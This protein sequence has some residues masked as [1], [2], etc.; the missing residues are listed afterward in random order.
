MRRE[1]RAQANPCGPAVLHNGILQLRDRDRIGILHAEQVAHRT[2]GS[3][4]V[5]TGT[6]IVR[7]AVVAGFKV[8]LANVRRLLIERTS[9][10]TTDRREGPGTLNRRLAICPGELT[11]VAPV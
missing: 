6:F 4:A 7:L 1:F 8:A 5:P 3:N 11:S 10:D 2:R 9:T